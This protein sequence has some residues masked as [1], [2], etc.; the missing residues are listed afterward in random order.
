MMIWR[1]EL[2]KANRRK[3]DQD[4]RHRENRLEI[5]WESD[6]AVQEK[7]DDEVIRGRKVQLSRLEEEEVIEETGIVVIGKRLDEF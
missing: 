1:L 3:S 2:R 4:L 5:E 7:E 6:V